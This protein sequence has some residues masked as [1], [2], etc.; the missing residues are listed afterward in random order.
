VKFQENPPRSL[1]GVAKTVFFKEM[2][3]PEAVTP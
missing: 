1:G 3:I 2:I